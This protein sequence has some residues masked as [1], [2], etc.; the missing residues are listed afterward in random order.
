M[1]GRVKRARVAILISPQTRFERGILDGIAHFLA[2]AGDWQA[3][4]DPHRPFDSLAP[5]RDAD[6]AIT[7]LPGRHV[8][9]LAGWG[10]PV[11]NTSSEA[12]DPRFAGNVL[13]DDQEV[14]RLVADD[15]CGRGFE[16]FAVVRQAHLHSA[17][18]EEGFFRAVAEAGFTTHRF[19]F[20]WGA[21]A[22]TKLQTDDDLLAWLR[23]LPKPIG[24][25][26][27]NDVLGNR[28]I[29]VAAAAGLDVPESIAVVGVDNDAA[30]CNLA[31]PPLSS[32]ALSTEHVGYR[33]A[34]IINTVLNG[35]PPPGG[36]TSV[37]VPPRELVQRQSSNTLA[38]A[39]P[40][41]A[42]VLAFIRQHATEGID[43]NRVLCAVPISRRSLEMRFR[44]LLGRSPKSEINRVQIE[45]A[46][47]LLA[48]SRLQ[49]SE[50]AFRSGFNNQTRFGVAFKRMMGVTP[51]RYR[52]MFALDQG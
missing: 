10:R 2:D 38:V 35:Q 18:R 23:V 6:A 51:T 20:G 41:I 36:V 12:I 32:V 19:N 7:A 27:T 31:R 5:L 44:R 8:G 34:Q 3:R 11:V 43:V 46:K 26:A 9:S 25:L 39:D 24:I 28:V 17:Q 42:A 15:L 1:L 49:I 40:E 22:P 4:F 45:A 52:K 48:T 30:L 21:P 16:H 14:G 50:V 29:E 37:R 13:C 47:A 33:A